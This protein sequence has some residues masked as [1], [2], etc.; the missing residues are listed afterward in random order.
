VVVVVVA[1]W[2]G[3]SSTPVLIN[4]TCHLCIGFVGPEASA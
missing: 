3:V 2:P 4:R 1:S